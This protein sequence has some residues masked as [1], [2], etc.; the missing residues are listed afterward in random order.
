MVGGKVPVATQ[1]VGRTSQRRLTGR[2]EFGEFV[3]IS[4][5]HHGVP[6]V[7]IRVPCIGVSLSAG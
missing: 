7:S 4:F 1:K 2:D 5:A 3:G 6:L